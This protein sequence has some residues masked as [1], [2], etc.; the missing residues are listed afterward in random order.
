MRVNHTLAV[1]F[2]EEQAIMFE[3][4]RPIILLSNK[5]RINTIMLAIFGQTT[6]KIVIRNVWLSL[7]GPVPQDGELDLAMKSAINQPKSRLAQYF[8][9]WF[10]RAQYAWAYQF[11]SK[12][13]PSIVVCWNGTKGNRMMLML[14]AKHTGHDTLYLEE[15][16][17]PG[18]ISIDK[19]GIN[20]ANSVPRDSRFFLEWA[21]MNPGSQSASALV[22]KQIKQRKAKLVDTSKVVAPETLFKES[23]IFCPLQVPGDSQLTIYGGQYDTVEKTIAFLKTCSQNLPKGVHFRLKEHPSSKIRFTSWIKEMETENFRLDNSSDTFDM[24]KHSAGVLTVNSSVGLESLFF[25]K[26]V[27]TLGQAFYAIKGIVTEV[28]SSADLMM[29]TEKVLTNNI[30]STSRT[31]FLDYLSEVHFPKESEVLS[32]TYSLSD[33]ENRDKLVRDIM[34]SLN[35]RKNTP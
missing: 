4:R 11:L 6:D 33:V 26:P 1:Y 7:K 2:I 3:V 14:A 31:A 16:P 34:K 5:K 17:L 19:N 23:Y 27:A 35:S 9:R 18:R 24:V 30:S 10:L 12:Q 8:K 29:W 32:G 20:F 25:D 13:L 28:A 15:S 22:R 21:S